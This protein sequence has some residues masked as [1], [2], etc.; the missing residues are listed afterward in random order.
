MPRTPWVGS[1]RTSTDDAGLGRGGGG[2][3]WSV[4]FDLSDFTGMVGF[5]ESNPH[6]KKIKSGILYHNTYHTSQG[7]VQNN[8]IL[9]NT[10][11]FCFIYY[12]YMYYLLRVMYINHI[13]STS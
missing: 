9:Y 12:F 13:Y 4:F 3:G 2:G 6:M 5:E 10:K 1:S 8:E 7:E 11:Y